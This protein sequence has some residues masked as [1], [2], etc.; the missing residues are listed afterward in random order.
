[1]NVYIWR[2][3]S[4]RWFAL[5]PGK[6]G[7]SGDSRAETVRE[8][9]EQSPK[10]PLK[11][12]VPSRRGFRDDSPE[13]PAS[14]RLSRQS[15]SGRVSTTP[16]ASQPNPPDRAGRADDRVTFVGGTSIEV[17]NT[18]REAAVDRATAFLVRNG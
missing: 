4:G 1:V 6:L 2:S 8:A 12:I 18:V 13:R 5:A 17:T 15:Q 16:P 3:P 10:A 14:P 11:F 9:L 7:A